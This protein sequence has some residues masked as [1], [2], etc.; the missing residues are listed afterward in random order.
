M[1]VD[2]IIHNAKIYTVDPDL[3]WAEA[4][5]MGNGRILAVGRNDEILPLAGPETELLDGNGRLVLP[6][7]TDSH[8]HFLQVAIRNHQISLFGMADFDEVREKVATAVAQAK[9]G[10]WVQGWGWDENLWSRL[11]NHADLDD[12]APNTPVALARMDMHTWWVNSAAL[13]LAGITAETPDPPESKFERD[14]DGNPTGILREWNAIEQVDLHIPETDEATLAVWL[15][16]AMALAHSLGLTG[17]HDQRVENEG[18][19]SFRLFQA[20]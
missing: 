6:G 7:F 15:E 19:L 13:K 9:P 12:I 2:L 5:A 4:V 10:E 14:A 16:E 18:D 11:P 17:L 1:Y 8:V 20:L 3:P